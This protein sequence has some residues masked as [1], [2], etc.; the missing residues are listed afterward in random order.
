MECYAAIQKNSLH[1]PIAHDLQGIK[2][3]GGGG[4][5]KTY[6]EQGEEQRVED[7]TTGGRQGR[8][9]LHKEKFT[10]LWKYLW[11]NLQATVVAVGRELRAGVRGRQFLLLYFFV[12]YDFF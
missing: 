11:K 8:R 6:R 12:P 3:V 1:V 2:I 10:Y 9:E 7:A 5:K 4:D